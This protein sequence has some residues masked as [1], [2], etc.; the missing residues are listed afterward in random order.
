VPK[1]YRGDLVN[2]HVFEVVG[3]NAS[4]DEF[5]IHNP[6]GSASASPMTFTMSAHELAA[7]GC[8]MTVAEGSATVE[9][10]HAEMEASIASVV[11][12]SHGPLAHFLV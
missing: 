11:A 2:S 5:T 1:E 7:A 8:S 12:A 3:Y 6:W 10:A 9:H 4:T